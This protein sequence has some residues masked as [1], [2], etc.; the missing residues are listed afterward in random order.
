MTT[1]LPV[2]TA[3]ARAGALEQALRLFEQGGYSA[4]TSDPAALAVKGRLTKD[5]ALATSTAGG[6]GARGALFAEAAAAY[7]AADALGPQPYLLINAATLTY[8]SGMQDEGI[9]LAARVL[10]RLDVPGVAETPYWIAA[11]RAEAL[12]LSGERDAAN[13]ALAS[14]MALDPDGW[15]DHASTLRQLALICGAGGIDTDWLEPHRPPRSLHFAGHLGVDADDS[16]ALAAEVAALLEA[17][18]IGFGYGALAAGADIIIA[19][20][21]IAHGAELH[22]VLPTTRDAFIDQSVVPYG[23]DWLPRFEA[24]MSGATSVRHVSAVAGD[25]EPLATA[26]AGEVAMGA[27]LQNA[28]MLQSRGVQ[29]LIVDEG[30]GD[31]GN[32]ASTARDGVVWQR[33]GAVQ[34]RMV[35][36]RRPAITPSA[37]RREGRDDRRLMALLHVSF[38]GLDDLNDAGYAYSLDEGLR[39][40]WA[41]A[42]AMNP[43]INQPHGNARMFGFVS[44]LAA[45]NFA[46]ALGR[47]DPGLGYPLTI[48]GHYGLVHLKDGEVSGPA[49]PTLITIAR[50][51][52]SG[53]ITVSDEFA[54]ALSLGPDDRHHIQCIGECERPQG[55]IT[56]LYGIS[57]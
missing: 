26:L 52:L 28:R 47:A 13:A 15:S 20:A 12:L 36:P 33:S 3:L 56:T 40:F 46:A 4:A 14:A 45:A 5:R 21:L 25:Y 19:E 18:K 55:G 9:A 7:A 6:D 10:D 8:L 32:G 16:A 53:S 39:T 50:A 23:E 38:D 34:H 27:A 44:L 29:L 48:A 51:T 30:G 43:I 35:W 57:V 17:E 41:A 2:I 54:A 49:L 1:P 22:A 42:K 31:Y 11:T 24:C 37:A